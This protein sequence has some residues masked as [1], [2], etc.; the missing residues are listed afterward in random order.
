[1][2]DLL[3]L[4]THCKTCSYVYACSKLYGNSLKHGKHVHIIDNATTNC[5]YIYQLC[6]TIHWCNEIITYYIYTYTLWRDKPSALG[7]NCLWNKCKE[8]DCHMGINHLPDCAGFLWPQNG[9]DVQVSELL[10]FI[11]IYRSI[12][13]LMYICIDYLCTQVIMWRYNRLICV[14]IYT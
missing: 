11:R 13:A 7:G 9:G 8:R 4:Y 2:C 1:M 5:V 10:Y 12:D 14:H 6:F 3:L